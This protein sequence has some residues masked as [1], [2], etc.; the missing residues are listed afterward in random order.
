[1]PHKQI[2]CREYWNKTENNNKISFLITE[3]V[4]FTL[5]FLMNRQKTASI[6]FFPFK[7]T[8]NEQN[9]TGEL[10]IE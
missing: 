9:D 4:Q 8:Q 6:Q 10:F 3:E 2:K 5:K 1:M 7:N